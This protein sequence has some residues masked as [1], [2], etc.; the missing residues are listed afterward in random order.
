MSTGFQD[1]AKE[2]I[3]QMVDIVDLVGQSINLERRGKLFLGHCPWHTDNRPSLQVDPNR[4]TWKCWPCNLGGDIFSFIMQRE[5]VEFREALELL[6][7]IAGVELKSSN[8]PKAAPG[9]PDDKRT[10]FRAAGW[11][12][13]LFHHHLLHSSEAAAARQYL[14][15]R[16]ITG[17]SIKKYKVGYTPN[18]WEF[19][20][21]ES[22]RTEFSPQVLH[23]CAL[24]GYSEKRKKHYDF[25][26]GRIMFPI[27]DTRDRTVAF[28]GRILPQFADDK[29]AKYVNSPETKIF[30]K[31]DNLYGIDVALDAIRKGGKVLVMEGYTDVI[32]ASQYG[33]SNVVAVLGTAIN[34]IHVRNL[35]R[36]A[37]VVTLV[38]DGDDAGK[39]RAN[40]VLE[41]FVKGQLDLRVLTLPEGLDPCDYL[42]TNGT[43]AFLEL[44]G[45]AADALQHKLDVELVNIDPLRD[46]HAANAALQSILKTMA[47]VSAEQVATDVATRQREQLILGRLSR[48]FSLELSE[49][50]DQLVALRHQSHSKSTASPFDGLP[51]H[52]A[53]RQRIRLT[54]METE[55]LELLT[56]RPDLAPG[57]AREIYVDDL[58]SG[59]MKYIYGI[60]TNRVLEG[61][62]TTFEDILLEIEDPQLKFV[63]VDAA[64]NAKNKASKTQ[65]TPEQR[66]DSLISTISK[67]IRDGERRELMRKIENKEVSAD[68]E[69]DLLQQLID[70][71]REDQGLT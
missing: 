54:P 23:A 57:A 24:L 39:K 47:L 61:L 55:L 2:Q 11:A 53:P 38:L 35:K 65:L 44:T 71:E 14:Q 56:E 68:E 36:L 27:H 45:K 4:Q 5:G 33:I 37:D 7:D 62:S 50:H 59:A 60:Y 30:S 67:Q 49:I 51:Q 19:L 26:R 52:P 13:E 8:R 25:F 66:L 41:Y 22:G 63:L 40:E 69:A 42:Q 29:N 46:I 17:D 64:E 28:G 48:T 9:S 1:D 3:R 15:N 20:L 32:M 6:A 43:E 70:Q 21:R 18:E 34:E 10:L 16:G 12:A 31:S 58:A